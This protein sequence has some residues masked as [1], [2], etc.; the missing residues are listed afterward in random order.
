VVYCNACCIVYFIIRIVVHIAKLALDSKL[1][2]GEDQMHFCDSSLLTQPEVLFSSL[3]SFLRITVET[4]VLFFPIL[5]VSYYQSKS[6]IP[7]VFLIYKI[8]DFGV[9][10]Y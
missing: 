4:M 9:L 8:A 10:T 2:L 5:D 1:P 3:I 7:P 6:I